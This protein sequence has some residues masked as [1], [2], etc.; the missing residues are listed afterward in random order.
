M[1]L[2]AEDV[3]RALAEFGPTTAEE[4]ALKTGAKVADVVG[5]LVQERHDGRI[6]EDKRPNGTHVYALVPAGEQ[7]LHQ[8]D[9]FTL[10][11]DFLDDRV[12]PE[13]PWA[14]ADA[15]GEPLELVKQGLIEYGLYGQWVEVAE[16]GGVLITSR[17]RHKLEVARAT[18][19][20]APRLWRPGQARRPIH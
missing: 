8:A 6:T 1:G 4:I 2:Q 13:Q 12:G 9:A 14:V 20:L 3:W 18:G 10:M 16:N 11:L 15:L 5:Y 17:G 7:A 19:R